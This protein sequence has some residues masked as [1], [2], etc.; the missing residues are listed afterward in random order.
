MNGTTTVPEEYKDCFGRIEGTGFG[1]HLTHLEEGMPWV[2]DN[3]A[4]TGRPRMIKINGSNIASAA[5]DSVVF[6]TVAFGSF[7]P[8]VTLGQF[9]A[10]VLGGF[11]WSL[12]LNRKEKN[13]GD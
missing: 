12:I 5:V 9:V 6:P 4:F 8:I 10:K 3:G 13:N 2:L 1:H 7:L 11:I